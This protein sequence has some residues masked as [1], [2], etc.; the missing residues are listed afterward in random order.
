MAR[1]EK[2]VLL[3]VFVTI[4]LDLLGF[5]IIIPILPFYAE[6]FGAAPSTVTWLGASYS[7]MQLI[8]APVWGRLSDRFGRRPIM[9]TSI[10]A[11]MVGYALFAVADDLTLLFAARLLAGFGNANIGTAQAAIADSTTSANRARGMGLI[12]AAFGLG[13]ILGPALGGVMGQ[14]SPA[15]PAWLASAL[16]LGNLGMAFFLF[17]ETLP[18]SERGANLRRPRVSM[19]RLVKAPAVA[20][21]LLV[22]LLLSSGFS[23]IEQTLGLLIEE[24][25][26]IGNGVGSAMVERGSEAAYRMGA[27]LTAQYLFF[28]GVTAAI[29]QG[30]LLGRL[31]RRFG[32]RGL[33]GAGLVLIAIGFVAVSLVSMY[34]PF[35]ALIPTAFLLAAGTGLATPSLSS[36]LSKISPSDIQ[37][38]SLGLGQ[39]ASALGRVIG[40]GLSGYLFEARVQLPFETAAV[41]MIAAFLALLMVPGRGATEPD[42]TTQT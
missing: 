38:R 18:E 27:A 10:A 13:F 9:L 41:I 25:W 6:Q 37:G 40:P 21:V 8:F 28:V 34:G 12:G 14:I 5:G 26:V 20:N 23:M 17:K 22:S 35:A 1:T 29:V 33:I 16:A 4:F 24:V 7:L 3:T 11:S 30:V 32:E 19:A 36:L 42:E 31:S 39:S 2:N 15:A